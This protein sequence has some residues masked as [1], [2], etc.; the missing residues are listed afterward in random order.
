MDT[1]RDFIRKAA[2]LSGAAGVWNAMPGSIQ[3]AMAIN[4]PPGSTWLDAEHVVILMQ[5][6]RSFDH[7]YGSLQGVRGYND[8]RA[9]NLPNKNLVWLQSN[10]KGETFAP[11]RLDIKNTKATWMSSLPHSWANQVDARNHGKYDKWLLVKQ[12]GNKDWAPMPLTMGFYDRR[13]IPFYYAMADAFTVCDQNF[14]SSLTGT[15]PN[16]LY[17]WSGT[18]RDSQNP[19]AKANVWNEDVDYGAEAHWNT[20]PERMQDNGISWKIYQNEISAANLEGEKDGL[21]AN[22]TD[23]PIEWF[24]AFNVRYAE[25][26]R[27]YVQTAI[28]A[29]TE[30]LKTKKEKLSTLTADTADYKKLASQIDRGEKYLTQLKSDAEKYTPENFAKLS[31]REQELHQRAFTVNSND[32]HYHELETLEYKDGSETRKVSVPKGDILHQFRADVN[33]GKLPTVSYLV[34]PG[35]FSDHPGSPWYGAWYVS[36]VLDI[37]TKQE[38][39]WKKTIFVLCYDENDG[40]FDH[41][42]PFTAPHKPGTGKVSAGID[43]ALEYVSLEEEKQKKHVGKDSLR[44]SPIGLGYRVPLVIASPWSRG[45]YVNSEICDHTSI[46]QLLENFLSHKTGKTIRESNISSYRRTICGDLSSVFR[47]YNGEQVSLPFEER[48]EVMESI[49]NAKFKKLPDNFKALTAEEIAQINATPQQSSWMPQQEKGTRPSC[50]LPYEL[51]THGKLSADK[52][53]FEISFA[54]AKDVFGAKAMGAPFNVYAP[55]NYVQAD[56]QQMGPMRAWSYAVKA[57]DKIADSW[58]L[59]EFEGGGY[60]LRLYGANGYYREFEGNASDPQVSLEC[61]YEK[62]KGI[63]SKLTGN[64]ALQVVNNESHPVTITAT[65]MS[66]GKGSK[67]ITVPAKGKSTLLIDL[68]KNHG[69]YDVRVSV[70][71]SAAF[72]QRYA[73]RVETGAN[74]ISDPFMGRVI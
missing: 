21:L 35:E 59:Q 54:A 17:L 70:D 52:R 31:K 2:L 5:E 47:P 66:Y 68:S 30:E 53:S 13:D 7:C 43:T 46:T 16:R 37:L 61:G 12:S 19:A 9:I 74:S 26:Y 57:G 45:G 36:E 44:E 50:A 25:G 4:P 29:I 73:G 33:G 32:P 38:E 67:K 10:E 8:P 62:Q 51:Y 24:A 1:R 41:V 18:L 22:F 14:C 48:N 64:V 65:D 60:Q 69:W 58:P 20:F 39:V 56:T 40:Y 28:P 15:T 6:N 63:K 55:G 71:G 23:N 11:F 49:F 72:A 42:P 34:A 3:R 27:K